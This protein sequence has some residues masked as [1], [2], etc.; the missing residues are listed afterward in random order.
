MIEIHRIRCTTIMNFS[1]LL[2]AN[3]VVMLVVV[4]DVP[5]GGVDGVSN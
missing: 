3:I 2:V 4:M 5:G 1:L